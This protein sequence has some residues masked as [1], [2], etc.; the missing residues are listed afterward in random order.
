MS[1]IKRTSSTM[2]LIVASFFSAIGRDT[3]ISQEQT[4]VLA[5]NQ[6][7]QQIKKHKPD[8]VYILFD[9]TPY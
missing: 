1:V 4:L 5:G 7:P 6:F 8:Q 9:G 3:G 2:L